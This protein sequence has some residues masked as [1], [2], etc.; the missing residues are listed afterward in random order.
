MIWLI[1]VLKELNNKDLILDTNLKSISK[2]NCSK[3]EQAKRIKQYTSY[4]PR[5]HIALPPWPW[6][7][8]FNNMSYPFQCICKGISSIFQQYN[9]KCSK[10]DS[11]LTVRKLTPTEPIREGVASLLVS[12]DL[13]QKKQNPKSY[14]P[15]TI[16][17]KK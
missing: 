17:T 16:K 8:L 9:I 12:K 1:L 6:Q 3:Q 2:L 4:N 13:L 5:N 14:P 10:N 11:P 15:P 7:H